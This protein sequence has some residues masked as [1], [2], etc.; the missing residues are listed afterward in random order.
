[1]RRNHSSRCA[2]FRT[3]SR[4]YNVVWA[5]ELSRRIIWWWVSWHLHRIDSLVWFR[6]CYP[7]SQR[8]SPCD[9][10]PWN[11]E[12]VEG[13]ITICGNR[14]LPVL[15]S[16]RIEARR[17]WWSHPSR[18]TNQ[19]SLAVF[20][21]HSLN[22][23]FWSGFPLS[24][25]PDIP[26]GIRHDLLAHFAKSC[27]SRPL[28]ALCKQEANLTDCWFIVNHNPQLFLPQKGWANG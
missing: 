8:I 10:C 18:Q 2:D 23:P 5:S 3:D 27:H 13:M 12:D 21:I 19:R 25:P 16:N 6:E 17:N 9:W 20:K 15:A 14:S 26:F 1:M 11:G 28:S 4:V 24:E 7:Y 22:Q